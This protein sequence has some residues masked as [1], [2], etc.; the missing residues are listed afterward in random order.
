MG[1]FLNTSSSRFSGQKL[2]CLEDR[3][4]SYFV[5]DE[6]GSEK[7]L[8]TCDDKFVGSQGTER[9]LVCGALRA[10]HELGK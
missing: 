8:T 5:I 7:G 2:E 6:F 4:E 1:E 3:I 10:S 9:C